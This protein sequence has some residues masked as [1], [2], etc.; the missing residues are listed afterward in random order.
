MPLS[1]SPSP[2]FSFSPA[3]AQR[4]FSLGFAAVMLA[5]GL[6]HSLS[7]LQ[8]YRAHGG[9][10]PWEPFLWELSSTLCTALLAPLIYRLHARSLRL[11]GWPPAL[12]LHLGGALGYT[13]LH[14][15]GMFGLRFAVYALTGVAY[16]PGSPGDIVIYEAGKDVVSYGFIVGLCHGLQLHEASRQREQ[17]LLRLQTE[18]AEAR[19]TRLAEQIQPHFLFNTLNLISSVMYE[20]VARADRIVCD[21][22]ALL[23][24]ALTAQENGR[25]SLAQELDLI[26]P[27]LAIMQ[28]RFGERLQVEIEASEAARACLLPS[29]LLI[30]PVE[31]AITH[32]VA[33]STGPVR[34]RLSAE[35]R[36]G[37]LCLRV[38]NSGRAPAAFEREGSVGLANTRERLRV[39]YGE[40]AR[41]N[42]AAD[43]AGG[44]VLDIEL[45][46][47]RA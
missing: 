28:A 24:Q 33:H 19:L 21:L 3:A 29:L 38:H 37:R 45:P 25:H 8:Q 36:A 39:L 13:A 26:Q 43:G 2:S 30:A 4:R 14:V 5:V 46:E 18:L 1:S 11:P 31:N 9:Q 35:L 27:Y 34:L 22:A 16:E 20:D 44:T 42:L 12:A 23:R 10:H 6:L 15:G 32:D 17:D 47:Q 7:E 40:A 41:V